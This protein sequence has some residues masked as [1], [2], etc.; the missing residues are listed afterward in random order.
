MGSK[1]YKLSSFKISSEIP[2]YQRVNHFHR[3]EVSKQKGI[4][5]LYKFY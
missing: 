3:N 1:L 4:Y 5:F 2:F